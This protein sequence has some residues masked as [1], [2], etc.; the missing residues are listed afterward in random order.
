MNAN[1]LKS[2]NTFLI[3]IAGFLAELRQQPGIVDSATVDTLEETASAMQ[4]A[5]YQCESARREAMAAT[6]RK[7]EACDAARDHYRAVVRQIRSSRNVPVA[8]ERR[9]GIVRRPRN[10]RPIPALTPSIVE[11]HGFETGINELKIDTTGNKPGT[12]YIVE[13]RQEDGNF[14]F[15][16]ISTT[17]RFSHAGQIP[18]RRVLYR[19]KASRPGGDSD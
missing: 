10:N 1:D 19:V 3:A 9:V 5:V 16:G 4:V 2:D 13:A 8:L 14:Q 11:V 12:T 17:R 18:G 6:T 15:A 7:R